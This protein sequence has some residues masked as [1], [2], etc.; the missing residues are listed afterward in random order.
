VSM[1]SI[2]SRL[3]G[4]QLGT[5]VLERLIGSGGMGMVYLA[6]QVRP[7]REVA[8]K[9]LNFDEA[10]EP[11]TRQEFL[12]RFQREANVIAQLD[13][14]NILPIYEYGEQDEV[15][16]LVM[17]YLTGGSLRDLLKRREMLAPEE[18]LSYLEQAAAALQYAHDHKVVHR[19]IKPGNMLFHSDGRLVLVDF[20][21]AHIV[22]EE[23]EALDDTL[24]GAGHFV[25]SVEYM[26]PEMVDNQPIDH[27]TDLYELG[28]V[29]F[30]MLTGRVPFRGPTTLAIAYKQV[31]ED[32]PLPSSLNPELTPDID[33]VVLKAIA[34]RP[35]E[36]YASA[37]EFARA[38]R[39]AVTW[40]RT[41]TE[42]PWGEKSLLA[43]TD[44]IA[45]RQSSSLHSFQN[46]Q[47]GREKTSSL[48]PPEEK[49]TASD[50]KRSS[51][52][53]PEHTG[54]TTQE[55][56]ATPTV[57]MPPGVDQLTQ[58]QTPDGYA[59][60]RPRHGSGWMIWTLIVCCLLLLALS[61]GVIVA[62]N[63]I[64]L[65]HLSASPKPTLSPAPVTATPAV[66]P[67]ETPEQMAQGLIQQYYNDING[68]DF[69][70]AYQLWSAD[71]RSTH[72]LQDFEQGF[73]STTHDDL[74][75]GTAT[76]QSNGNVIVP[77]TVYA[78][79]QSNNG[80]TVSA[81]R[82]NYTVGNDGGVLRLLRANLQPVG[83][84][85]ATPTPQGV[86]QAQQVV[87]SYYDALNQHD[88]QKAYQLWGTD[89]QQNHPYDQ[90]A[91]GFAAMQHDDLQLG[92]PAQLSDGVYRVDVTV[93]AT[94]K[95]SNGST[96]TSTY[97]G[98]YI[99]EEQNGTLVLETADLQKTN[100]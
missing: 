30:Q 72:S 53:A 98:S 38:F 55:V 12:A 46:P 58:A 65:L 83:G 76:T 41:A 54:F 94:E 43:N 92:T 68:Q 6:R 2:G 80:T 61:V 18:A 44:D 23:G 37:R 19:D 73:A 75:F 39:E 60:S 71:Y 69:Q 85:A 27:R 48:R 45:E 17:P 4:K 5:C 11:G 78:T 90:F 93:T 74:A 100:S 95:A 14:V 88:Y 87:Q 7:M 9:V 59:V 34:K 81:Y 57:P 91:A 40:S 32:A 77:L 26:A 22:R 99:V 79:D 66:T 42:A 15:P 25:G 47:A 84:A 56:A 33:R 51:E 29:L 50:S 21:I 20:G 31:H 16:Y 97:A 62:P 49:Y 24:T 64:N 35:E 13:H 67:T 52:N 86:A 82:G 1:K 28:V 3:I 36:R 96:T 70:A 10:R 89:Y 8:V 63:L